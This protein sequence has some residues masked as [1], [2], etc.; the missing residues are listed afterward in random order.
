[1]GWAA[2]NKVSGT[3]NGD[4]TITVSDNTATSARSGIITIQG[5]NVAKT[6]TL[7][8]EASKG[9]T[10]TFSDPYGYCVN[11]PDATFVEVY[12]YVQ[13]SQGVTI[14]SPELASMLYKSDSGISNDT[15]VF[16]ISE[17]WPSGSYETTKVTATAALIDGTGLKAVVYINALQAE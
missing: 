2:V 6:V 17:L 9:Y 16:T 1:M 11:L 5:Q 12:A 15:G 4:F 8:Q 10:I 13:N 14:A 7:T 3:G